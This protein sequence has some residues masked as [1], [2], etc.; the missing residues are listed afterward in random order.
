[1]KARQER[2]H[3][4]TAPVILNYTASF[5]KVHSLCLLFIYLFIKKKKISLTN[6]NDIVFKCQGLL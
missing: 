4:V 5:C 1:M 6:Y 2:R 3:Y